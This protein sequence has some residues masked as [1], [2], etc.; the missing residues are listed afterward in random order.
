M[1]VSKNMDF[2]VSRKNYASKVEQSIDSSNE[3]SFIAVPGPEGKQGIP[4]PQGPKGDP[5][6]SIVGPKG[7]K[8][9]PGKPGKDGKSYFPVYEQKAGWAMYGNSSDRFVKLGATQG[10]DG[11]VSMFVDAHQSQTEE[12][13][14]PEGS[15]SLYNP[16]TRK[17]NLRGLKLGSQV[18]VTYVLDISTMSSNTEVWAR[19]SIGKTD[20]DVYSFVANL[21][22][23]DSYELSYTHTVHIKSESIKSF[24][25]SPQIRTDYPAMGRLKSITVSVS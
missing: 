7:D 22:Y 23:E 1:S 4:G 3:V 21:K 13:Y 24:G 5:G 20:D 16:E 25:I 10:D 2:P 19:S 14:L 17:V 9:D 12:K 15:V 6:E 8:G 11:W 18:R